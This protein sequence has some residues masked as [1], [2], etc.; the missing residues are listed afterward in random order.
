MDSDVLAQAA[1]LPPK[2]RH[3]VLRL[4]GLGSPAL[5]S[6]AAHDHP[7]TKPGPTS[8]RPAPTSR[9]AAGSEALSVAIDAASFQPPMPHE[10]FSLIGDRRCCVCD[11]GKPADASDCTC[12]CGAPGVVVRDAAL[13][14]GHAMALRE[15]GDKLRRAGALKPAV[16]KQ[17]WL[18]AEYRGDLSVWLG[19][20]EKLSSMP[21]AVQSFH[22]AV[23]AFRDMLR[24]AA[25]QLRLVDDVSIQLACYVRVGYCLLLTTL[26]SCCVLHGSRVMELAMCAI[27]TRS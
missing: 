4:A 26:P 22:A 24:Q 17:G 6:P 21:P 11:L 7:A 2:L 8:A 27:W 3:S 19:R 13:G 9:Y 16:M 1:A 25:P 23:C 15:A 5:S 18:D 14:S 12:S 20:G 10:V